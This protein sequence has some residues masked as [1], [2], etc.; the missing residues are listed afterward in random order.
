M[1]RAKQLGF[2]Y[3]RKKANELA[4]EAAMNVLFICSKNQWRSPTAERVFRNDPAL[5]VRSRGVSRSAR[6]TVTSQDL[7]WA[8]LVFVMESKHKQRLL[9]DFPGEMRFKR[10]EVL[11][12]PDEYKF[13]DQ[14]LVDLLTEAVPPLLR[15]DHNHA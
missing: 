15:N 10:I 5:E 8:D 7:K 1:H 6:R 4:S 11:D 9:G 12:I 2:D 13:M 14:E 3:P